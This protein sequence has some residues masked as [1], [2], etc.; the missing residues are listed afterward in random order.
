MTINPHI[1]YNPHS[2]TQ[3]RLIFHGIQIACHKTT[4]KKGHILWH[5]IF[6][7]IIIRNHIVIWFD[8]IMHLIYSQY[9][10]KP[11]KFLIKS[12]QVGHFVYLRPDRRRYD[13]NG[14]K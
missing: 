11:D 1:G 14:K 3:S 7:F 6:I 2:K 5:L 8:S 10:A 9:K 13:Y 12:G 4:P